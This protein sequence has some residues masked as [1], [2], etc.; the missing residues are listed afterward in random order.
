MV[1]PQWGTFQKPNRTMELEEQQE[2]QQEIPGGIE[3]QERPEAEKPQWGNF[4]TPSTY[5]GEPDP[6]AEESTLGYFTRNILTNASRVGEQILGKYGNTEKMTKDVLSNFPVSGGLLGLAISE[7]VGPEKWEKMVKGET[8]QQQILPTSAQLKEMS[9]KG[10]KG[11][12][13]PKT[14]GEENFQKYVE[15]IGSTIGGSRAATARN[16]A[17]NNV[18]IPAASNVVEDVVEGLG[19]GKD[20]AMVAKLGTWTALSLLGNVNAPE[21]AS[22]LMNQGRN[23]IPNNLNANIPRLQNRLQQVANNPHLLHADPRSALARQELAAIER[24]I[25]NGQTSIR[26][27]MTTYD[28]I[29]AAKRNRD[30][31]SL[32]RND[33]A[34]ARRAI[35]TVRDAVRDEIMDAGANHAG[36]LNSWRSGIQAWAVIH[37]SRA[38]TNWIDGLARGPYGKTISGPAAGLFGVT[39]YGGVKAPLI[40]GPAATAI[41][42][43]YKAGQTAYRVWQDPN[44][45]RYYWNAIGAAQRENLPT[46]LNNYNKLNKSLEKSDSTKKK[47]KSKEK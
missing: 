27:L 43:A 33:Q 13:E 24:D 46:F 14:K 34:F 10:T 4:D 17:I 36:A 23:G 3:D 37:Q 38:M 47:S 26:S 11:Y 8:G 28:G 15:D 18:G 29:N 31:F 21:Y 12:T 1:A 40:A 5:Q 25:A 41:P 32:N 6:I 30:L 2:M 45:S 35:D 39:T 44:L 19:F 7:L 22:N 16:V 20:K 9:V 42:A